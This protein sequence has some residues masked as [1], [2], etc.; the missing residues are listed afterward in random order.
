MTIPI[1]TAHKAREKGIR[2]N[3]TQEKEISYRKEKDKARQDNVQYP[4]E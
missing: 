3:N 1:S 2:T 4:T